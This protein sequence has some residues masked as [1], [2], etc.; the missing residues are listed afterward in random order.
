MREPI[1]TLSAPVMSEVESWFCCQRNYMG[2]EN[3]LFVY[4]IIENIT[5][6]TVYFRQ[7]HTLLTTLTW[8][9]MFLES[10]YRCE[11]SK[12]ARQ[13]RYSR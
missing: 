7:Y 2:F 3:S 11:T 13:S 8:Q 5:D 6:F 9:D 12:C 1:F 4:V 10:T